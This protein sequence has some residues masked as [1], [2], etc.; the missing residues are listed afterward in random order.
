M[1][2][3]H[4]LRRKEA[5]VFNTRRSNHENDAAVQMLLAA[6][7]QFAEL[8]THRL[9]LDEADRAFQMLETGDGG[10]AKIIIKL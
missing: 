10:A 1:L 7:K 3:L 4:Q 6:P 9:P 8:I 2:N 5:T